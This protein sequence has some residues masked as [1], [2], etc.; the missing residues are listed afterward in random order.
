MMCVTQTIDKMDY[1]SVC[2]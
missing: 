2:A 1:I